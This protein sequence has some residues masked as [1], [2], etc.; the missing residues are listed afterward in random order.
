MK[1]PIESM[2]EV[3]TLVCET[4][5]V[6]ER[7]LVGSC[8]KRE[9]AEPR[10]IAAAI[11][12]KLLGTSFKKIGQRFNKNHSTIIYYC[13]TYEDMYSKDKVFTKNVNRIL[14]HFK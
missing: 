4:F 7:D 8:K 10:M 9:F 3:I 14:N 6:L 12:R 13:D 2:E 11:I 1:L 5:D